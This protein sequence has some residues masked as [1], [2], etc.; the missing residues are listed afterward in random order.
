MPTLSTSRIV[1]IGGTSGIGFGV[2][3]RLAD[4][5]GEVVIASRN[6]DRV[7]RAVAEFPGGNVRGAVVDIGAEAAVTET[8][9]QLGPVDGVV[10]TAVE[11]RYGALR[12][13]STDDMTAVLR[14]K[15]IGP[16]LVARHAQIRSDL[17]VVVADPEPA[18]TVMGCVARQWYGTT[19]S[20]SG[21]V[22]RARRLTV[23]LGDALG[24][25]R[26]RPCARRGG[27]EDVEV[28]GWASLC[29]E[30]FDDA[31]GHGVRARKRRIARPG[32]QA[33]GSWS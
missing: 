14:S 19:S 22:S 4:H 32:G 33:I 1:V 24:A 2:A 6:P 31:D 13:L 25:R 20:G 8:F 3:A 28:T 7:A 21:A 30:D 26:C 29:G 18:A 27:G 5:G 9:A 11:A 12:T 10:I 17:A 15:L 23:H 16:L